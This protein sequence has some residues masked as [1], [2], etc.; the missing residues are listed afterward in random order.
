MPRRKTKSTRVF[1]PVHQPISLPQKR[2]APLTDNEEDDDD[3]ENFPVTKKQYRSSDARWRKNL[4]QAFRLLRDMTAPNH[5]E[6]PIAGKNMRRDI[7]VQAMS[8]I[9]QLEDD[10][11]L[12]LNIRDIRELFDKMECQNHFADNGMDHPAPSRKRKKPL[13]VQQ[14][15]PATA[16]CSSSAPMALNDSSEAAA[17]AFRISEETDDADPLSQAQGE[18]FDLESFLTS[19]P[20][21][22]EQTVTGCQLRNTKVKFSAAKRPPNV[23]RRLNMDEADENMV[24]DVA[25]GGGDC[26]MQFDQAVDEYLETSFSQLLHMSQGGTLYCEPVQIDGSFSDS[27]VINP[28]VAYDVEVESTDFVL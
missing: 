23:R 11:S 26:V 3:S 6:I 21:L 18:S 10:V 15:P 12:F 25:A 16:T 4:K 27:A 7:L 9:E 8:V 22:S 28:P 2:G 19:T 5:Y 14:M 20:K 24:M 17:A 13:T 1:N